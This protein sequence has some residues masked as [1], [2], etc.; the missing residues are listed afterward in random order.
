MATVEPTNGE[1]RLIHD[2]ELMDVEAESPFHLREL[3]WWDG[4]DFFYLQSSTQKP[5]D[6]DEETRSALSRDAILV[7][8]SLYQITPPPE[9]IRAPEPLP[10][11]SYMKAGVMYNFCPEDLNKSAI[12]SL[13]IQEAWVCEILMKHPHWNVM[14]SDTVKNGALLRADIE[15]SLN[16]IKQVIEHIHGLGL[17]HNDINP[18]NILFDDDGRLV[19]IDFDSCCK[20]GESMLHGKCGTFPFSNDPETAEF[21]NDFYGV[22][23]IREWM[24]EKIPQEIDE[25][26]V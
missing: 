19:I 7:P 15:S 5:R 6:K 18:R 8:R 14:L 11:D 26:V 17:V 12:W 16:Q 21:Q 22:E 10:R 3:L 4:E 1:R 13:M 2:I 24:E 20:Q 23:K 9:L 25:Y